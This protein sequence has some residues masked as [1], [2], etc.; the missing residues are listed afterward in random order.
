MTD[1]GENRQVFSGSNEERDFQ[2]LRRLAV[3]AP[4]STFS[5]FRKRASILQGTRLLF[6][7]QIH[8]FWIVLDIVLKRLFRVAQS[9]PSHHSSSPDIRERG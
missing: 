5:R 4:P 3:A 9:A 2:Q 7:S 1:Q 6:E 8:G